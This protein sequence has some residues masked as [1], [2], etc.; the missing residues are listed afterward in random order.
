MAKH[1]FRKPKVEEKTEKKPMMSF[2]SKASSRY[3][4]KAVQKGA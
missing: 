1:K 3:A 2:A 4:K